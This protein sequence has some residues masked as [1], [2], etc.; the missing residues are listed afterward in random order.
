VAVS[1]DL[2]EKSAGLECNAGEADGGCPLIG[3]LTHDFNNLLTAIGGHAALIE[4]EAEPGSETAES[5]A[6]ILKATVHASAIAERLG[7]LAR[8]KESKK[9]MVD[10]N[11]TVADVAALLRMTTS[12]AIEMRHELLAP[13]A[14]TLANP[15]QMHQLVLNLVLNA[16][17]AMPDGGLLTMETG[18][19]SS[20]AV[21]TVRDTG[22]GIAP[23][24]RDHI[25]EPY[26][27][28][29]R[30]RE[31]SGMGLAVVAGIVE[32]HGGT[33]HVESE[34]GSGTAIH[35]RLPR[36]KAQAAHPAG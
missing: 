5:A 29:R 22:Q 8:P 24:I 16:R 32:R 4:A 12:P 6:A 21:L 1:D 28:T 35:I 18:Q 9:V 3:G 23:E 15:A 17:E 11:T 10:L 26:V 19:E 27:S 30:N 7:N 33:I 25:F 34:P 20:H 13:A 31:G 14:V 2:R 36:A